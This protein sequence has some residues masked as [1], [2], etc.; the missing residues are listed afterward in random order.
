MV[1]FIVAW[2]EHAYSYVPGASKG[3]LN[4]APMASRPE[5]QLLSAAVTVCTVSSSFDQV[6]VDHRTHE[7]PL[8]HLLKP[9][10]PHTAISEYRLKRGIERLKVEHRL[11]DIEDQ[12]RHKSRVFSVLRIVSP[13]SC[14]LGATHRIHSAVGR[15]LPA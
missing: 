1:P 13:A 8:E 4:V 11:Y 10:V 9:L 7:C 14:T 2:I 12:T 6:T 3:W 5:S 15:A